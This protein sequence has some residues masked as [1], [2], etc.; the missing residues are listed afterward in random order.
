MEWNLE[1][2]MMIWST[3]DFLIQI[4]VCDYI[5]YI[6]KRQNRMQEKAFTKLQSK[7]RKWNAIVKFWHIRSLTIDVWLGS[8]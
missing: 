2:V 5:I 1:L 7:T 8:D 3:L 6:M 4:I